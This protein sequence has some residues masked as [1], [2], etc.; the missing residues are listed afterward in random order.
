ME[1]SSASL[2]QGSDSDTAFESNSYFRIT[3]NNP[4]QQPIPTPQAQVAPRIPATGEIKGTCHPLTMPTRSVSTSSAMSSDEAIPGNDP[5]NTSEL[6]AERLQAWKHAVGYLEAYITATEKVQ[7]AHSKEYEKVLKTVESPL[8]EGHHFDQNMGGIASLFETIRTNTTGLA[9]IHLETEKNIKGSVLPI[10][11]RLHKE[12]KNKSKEITAGAGKNAK[13]VEKVRNI[14]QKHIEL[15][16]QHTAGFGVSGGKMSANDD[17]YVVQRGVYHRLGKQILE[18]NNNKNDLI[19]V[20]NNFALFESHIIE[21]IQQA[22]MTFNQFVGGQAQKVE[23]LYGEMLGTAQAVPLNFEWAG[24]VE[25]NK[26]ILVDPQT[27]DRTLDG[28]TFPNQDHS[29]TRAVIEG[30]LERKS[31]NKLS[32]AGYSTGYYVVTPSKYLHEFKDSDNLRKDPT[33]ELSI[34]LPDAVIGTTNGE[35]FNVKGKDVSKGIGGKFTGSSELQFKAH[36]ASDA[37]KWYEAISSVVG[38]APASEPLSPAATGVVGPS[39]SENKQAS[40]PPAY[41]EKTGPAPVQ[42][43][44][45]TG[46]ETV[47]IPVAISSGAA[48]TNPE[49]I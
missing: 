16:G 12:I 26:E 29:C 6:L 11:D 7:R 31:R 36:T 23:Q 40:V 17:P 9:N 21:V 4:A 34:Y 2:Y 42:T 39:E 38:T 25:R 44:G 22:M 20:Q 27:P 41:A 10:L 5:S 49:K 18:E 13:E 1:K 37:N 32:M 33:P 48:A 24:F 28:I 14:T 46:G 47:A 15:L 19:N 45:L 35:K 8:K 30:T 3:D 43:A